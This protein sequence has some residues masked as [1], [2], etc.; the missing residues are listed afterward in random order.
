[1]RQGFWK[2]LPISFPGDKVMGCKYNIFFLF[3]FI[4]NKPIENNTVKRLKSLPKLMTVQ[5]GVN[6]LS[7]KFDSNK[8]KLK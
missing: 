8:K 1:M 7:F 3:L 2:W 4:A 6:A 5:N